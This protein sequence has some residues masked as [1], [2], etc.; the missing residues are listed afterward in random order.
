MRSR[1]LVAVLVLALTFTSD[2][3][4]YVSGGGI[5]GDGPPPGTMLAGKLTAIVGPGFT[6]TVK[7]GTA[8]VTT[9]KQGAYSITVD[10]KSSVHNFHITG[11]GV[12]LA[13]KVGAI[14]K[15]TWTVTLKPGTYKYFCDPHSATMKGTFK[16]TA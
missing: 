1:S 4:G 8:K 5:Y 11:P 12:N 14:I 15:R 10:D 6:I 16:V 7:K 9:L 13:T 3:T 2:V